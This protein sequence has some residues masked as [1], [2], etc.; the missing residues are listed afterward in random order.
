M[1]RSFLSACIV[2]ATLFC[3]HA[4]SADDLEA[5]L[6][7]PVVVAQDLKKMRA[8]LDTGAVL[9]TVRT[10]VC[11]LQIVAGG[12]GSRVVRM[13]ASPPPAAQVETRAW[14]LTADGSVITPLREWKTPSPPGR[15]VMGRSA[16]FER[17]FA[18][19][20]SAASNAIAVAISINGEVHV[21]QLVPHKD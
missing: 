19:P 11:T 2:M 9:W 5:T 3:D 6:A 15:V 21:E 12:P 16:G 18:F 20:R 1:K 17:L 14:L 13:P 4:F 7:Q 8:A 10:D